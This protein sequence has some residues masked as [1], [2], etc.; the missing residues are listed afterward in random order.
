M[1]CAR[2][3]LSIQGSKSLST[4][5]FQSGTLQ[6]K[7]NK[8]GFLTSALNVR[9]PLGW[10]QDSWL[11]AQGSLRAGSGEESGGGGAEGLLTPLGVTLGP[12]W[13]QGVVGVEWGGVSGVGRWSRPGMPQAC[14]DVGWQGGGEA[15]ATATDRVQGGSQGTRTNLCTLST[16]PE[17]TQA[18]FRRHGL[19]CQ[20][21]P[22]PAS[23]ATCPGHGTRASWA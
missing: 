20:E 9:S 5:Q 11:G 12:G 19:K 7:K 1:W 17:G 6:K 14:S 16:G 21:L 23:S 15:G 2:V 8:I 10:T 13:G 22:F 18:A 4:D 3:C